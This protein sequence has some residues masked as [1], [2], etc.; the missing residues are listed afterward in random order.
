MAYPLN[1]LTIIN[2]LNA[3]GACPPSSPLPDIGSP[4]G[5]LGR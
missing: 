4:G 5:T 3:A 1:S 2:N